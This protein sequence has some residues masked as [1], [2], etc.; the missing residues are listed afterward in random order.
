MLRCRLYISVD[1]FLLVRLVRLYCRDSQ[2]SLTR[3]PSTA[4]ISEYAEIEDEAFPKEMM[5][6]FLDS[7]DEDKHH[8]DPE[9]DALATWS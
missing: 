3:R 1:V 6:L 9:Y 2:L 4:E 5:S 8:S 7:D